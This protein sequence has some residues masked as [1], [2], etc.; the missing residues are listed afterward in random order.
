MGPL[1]DY[2]RPP[3]SGVVQAWFGCGPDGADTYSV[4]AAPEGRECVVVIDA[5]IS[6]EADREDVEHLIN[7]F[8][9]DCGRVTSGPLDASPSHS[10][11][12]ASAAATTASAS[13]TTG[14]TASASPCPNWRVTP[15]GLQCSNLPDVI[16][17][18]NRN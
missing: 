8:D 5:R 17:E 16:P 6:D 14:P 2:E 13:A 18:S 10:P 7:T 4:A 1:E 15:D 12:S 3:Y 11:A 9:V